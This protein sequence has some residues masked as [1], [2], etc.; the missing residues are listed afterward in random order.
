MKTTL[1]LILAG[2]LLS[3]L[4]FAEGMGKQSDKD[5]R[6]GMKHGMK[7]DCDEMDEGCMTEGLN[8][9]SE[10]KQRLKDIYQDARKKRDELREETHQKVRQVLTDE[11]E[12]K[13]E[14]NRSAIMQYRADRMRERAQQMDEKAGDMRDQ[15]RQERR[16]QR[17]QERK[18]Y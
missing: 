18:G 15:Q 6:H 9:T 12:K 4:A 7:F 3:P 17:E 11:Q 10:Q 2:S 14:A 1:A 5:G 16:E 13:L 8:L